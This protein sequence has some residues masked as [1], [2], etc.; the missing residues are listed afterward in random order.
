MGEQFTKHYTSGNK[1][2]IAKFSV[3]K[4][5]S[6]YEANNQPIVEIDLLLKSPT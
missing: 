3:I 6:D 4:S 2:N 5:D 1:I